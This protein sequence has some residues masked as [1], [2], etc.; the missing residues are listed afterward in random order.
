MN[1]H[2]T[3]DGICFQM[4]AHRKEMG[5]PPVKDKPLSREVVDAYR[6]NFILISQQT[7]SELLKKYKQRG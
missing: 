7:G 4:E 6:D 3:L 5:W 1:F 2:G